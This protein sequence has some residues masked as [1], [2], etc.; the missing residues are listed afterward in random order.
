MINDYWLNEN[1]NQNQNDN[2]N[3]NW[4]IRSPQADFLWFFDEWLM[5]NDCLH[6]DN[7][8]KHGCPQADLFGVNANVH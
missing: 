5:I 3:E 6:T 1:Q 7:T 4:V 8:E 2:K